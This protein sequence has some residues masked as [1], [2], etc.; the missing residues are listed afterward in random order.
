MIEKAIKLSERIEN[1]FKYFST[2]SADDIE[3]FKPK[4]LKLIEE[5]ED[6]VN[7]SDDKDVKALLNRVFILSVREMR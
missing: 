1:G 4:L 2:A 6:I 5:Y 7:K 3:K